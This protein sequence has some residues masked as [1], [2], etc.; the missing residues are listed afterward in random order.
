MIGG[1]NTEGLLISPKPLPFKYLE[2]SVF[3]VVS[4]LFSSSL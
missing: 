3:N 1:D 4:M 2:V